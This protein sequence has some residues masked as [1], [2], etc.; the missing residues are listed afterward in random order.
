[1][2][3]IEVARY[4]SLSIAVS[5]VSSIQQGLLRKCDLPLLTSVQNTPAS[6][7]LETTTKPFHASAL[8]RDEKGSKNF[9]KPSLIDW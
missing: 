7:Y 5:T 1:V 3:V 6:E 8:T 4:C 9:L 2:G